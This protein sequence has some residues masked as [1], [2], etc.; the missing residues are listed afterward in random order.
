[1]NSPGN[2]D[3]WRGRHSKYIRNHVY[4][5]KGLPETFADEN[6]NN[7]W[8]G[9]EETQIPIELENLRS[10][11]NLP[12]KTWIFSKPLIFAKVFETATT[13]II[14][15]LS[16]NFSPAGMLGRDQRP[17]WAGFWGGVK[18]SFDDPGGN[19]DPVSPIIRDRFQP[20]TLPDPPKA[21]N[22]FRSPLTLPA[23]RGE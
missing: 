14:S 6:L 12:K 10:A 17:T 16:K 15:A 3:P 11:L 1:M 4:L 18:G 5:N 20:R 8:Q 13:P 23:F 19:D 22:P 7:F 2:I 9:L 21:E